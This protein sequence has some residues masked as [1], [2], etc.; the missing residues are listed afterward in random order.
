MRY[1]WVKHKE[2]NLTKDLK[3]EIVVLTKAIKRSLMI[4]KKYLE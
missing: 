3:V 1:Q 2:K 4:I